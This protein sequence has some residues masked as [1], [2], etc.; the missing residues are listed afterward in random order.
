MTID[1]DKARARLEAKQAELR[2]HLNTL[3][4]VSPSADSWVK[5]S[6]DV[7]DREDVA[8]EARAIE[9]E[10]S[11]SESQ[12]RL[13]ADV[14]GA[15]ERIRQGKYG[16]CVQCHRPLP[17]KRLEVLPWAARDISCQQQFEMQNSENIQALPIRTKT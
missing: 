12:R 16:L 2:A 6:R 15:L 10:Q 8:A 11:I 17:E 9:E 7:Q 14:E 4:V 3:A 13:L 1:I 5:G